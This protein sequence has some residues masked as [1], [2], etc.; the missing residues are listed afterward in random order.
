MVRDAENKPKPEAA[1]STPRAPAPTET[2]PPGGQGADVPPQA[3]LPDE[4]TVSGADA[5]AP[6]SSRIEEPSH[7][8]AGEA[9]DREEISRSDMI[10]I[11]TACN[12]Q[13]RIS[14]GL[15]T[16]VPVILARM[17]LG[18]DKDGNDLAVADRTKLAAMRLLNVLER[19]D[20]ERLRTKYLLGLLNPEEGEVRLI[21]TP[22][23]GPSVDDVAGSAGPASDTPDGENADAQRDN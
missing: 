22:V 5:S 15:Y 23:A 1:D 21:R 17:I 11:Q 7:N 14:E 6:I 9:F 2:P 3:N 8:G 13:Y 4:S 18:R 12:R 10:L 20:L 19:T 16:A